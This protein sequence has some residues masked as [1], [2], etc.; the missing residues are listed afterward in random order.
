MTIAEAKQP[1]SGATIAVPGTLLWRLLSMCLLFGAWE[2]A[3]RIPIS[4]AF[5][6]FIETMTALGQMAADG[7]LFAAY[8]DTLK[9]LLIGVG[10]SGIFGV[11]ECHR[12]FPFCCVN[13]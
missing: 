7:R 11:A 12:S 9:P 3:G 2:I 13:G 1:P 4:V 8:A 10:V 6:S 5:P